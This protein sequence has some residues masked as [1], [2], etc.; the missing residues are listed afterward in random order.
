MDKSSLSEETE[1]DNRL[2]DSFGLVVLPECECVG[3]EYS[4][5]SIIVK[6]KSTNGC[7]LVIGHLSDKRI[8]CYYGATDEVSIIQG[9]QVIDL[10]A[11]GRRWEGGARGGKPCGYGIVYDEEGRKEYEGFMMD[12]IKTC[13]GI[14]YYRDIER[15]LYAGSYY[16]DKRF[17][18]GILYDRNGVVEYDGYWKNNMQYYYAFHEEGIVD[19]FRESLILPAHSLNDVDF[20][21]LP[22][23]IHSLKRIIVG[24][25]CFTSARLLEMDGLEAL[26]SV[27]IRKKSFIHLKNG[28]DILKDSRGDGCFRIASCPKLKSIQ[29]G[30]Y[31]FGDYHS[32]ILKALPSLY[33]IQLGYRCFQKGSSFSLTGSIA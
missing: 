2:Q 1:D 29:I 14:E 26:E 8:H 12:G 33:F 3:I 10:S 22:Y 27:V 11:D 21:I 18:K 30:D 16:D 13:Y 32:F 23:W 15:P 6:R 25:D 19:S 17:G 5:D 9:D 28:N 4:D 7:M 20:F 24:Y 31:S